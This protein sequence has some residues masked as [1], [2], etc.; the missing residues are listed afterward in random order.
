MFSKV[1]HS[2]VWLIR[3]QVESSPPMVQDLTSARAEKSPYLESQ[4][5]TVCMHLFHVYVWIV[6]V[7]DGEYL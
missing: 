3:Q 4:E 6:D 2:A 7:C 1:H 5:V